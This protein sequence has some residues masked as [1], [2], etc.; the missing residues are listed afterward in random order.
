M[1]LGKYRIEWHGFR[2]L[3]NQWELMDNC[4]LLGPVFV[5]WIQEDTE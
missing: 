5:W 1:R 3:W 4:A 2:H